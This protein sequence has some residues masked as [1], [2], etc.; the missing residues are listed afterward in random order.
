MS[1]KYTFKELWNR[2]PL[3]VRNAC[4]NC[5][6]DNYHHGEGNVD[7]HVELV[8]NYLSNK[9]SDN[10][11]LVS[12]IFHDLGKPETKQLKEKDGKI[13]ISNIGHELKCKYYIDKYLYLYSDLNL[14][15]NKILQV[16]ENHMKAHFYVCGKMTKPGKRKNFEALEYFE[17]IIKFTEAD[18][19]GRIENLNI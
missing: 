5:E 3:D 6:Q 10:D 15:Y 7:K 13:K 14:N 18:S 1:K 12:A 2:L 19:N 8:F 9:S 16:C 11:L 17:D 4:E